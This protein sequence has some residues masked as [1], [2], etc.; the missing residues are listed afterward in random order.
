MRACVGKAGRSERQ[1]GVGIISGKEGYADEEEADVSAPES[2]DGLLHEGRQRL[3]NRTEKR[4]RTRGQRE[5]PP[6]AAGTFR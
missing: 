1:G 2:G 5:R 6:L 4:H 3:R